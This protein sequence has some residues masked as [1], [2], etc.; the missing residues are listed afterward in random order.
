[1][2]NKRKWYQLSNETKSTLGG[3]VLWELLDSFLPTNPPREGDNE[4]KSF[5]IWLGLIFRIFLLT[6]V[7]L[8]V[9]L[10]IIGGVISMVGEF[11]RNSLFVY[12][13][14]FC[15]SIYLLISFY[16]CYIMFVSKHYLLVIF[17][18]VLNIVISKLL[19]NYWILQIT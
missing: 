15:F 6:M 9:G 7:G 16:C 5:G 18:I 4:L 8:Y 12:L 19:L 11:N 2:G 14:L 17:F 10:I 3:V 1:M 13:H